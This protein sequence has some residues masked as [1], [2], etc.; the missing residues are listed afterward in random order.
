MHELARR[1]AIAH[2]L[3]QLDDRPQ[4]LVKEELFSECCGDAAFVT[5][6]ASKELTDQVWNW[7]PIVHA[8]K[9]ETVGQRLAS[10]VDDQMEFKAVEP[11]NRR[12]AAPGIDTKDAVLL[13]PGWMTDSE[14]RRI[15][16]A[17][18]GAGAE[19]GVQVDGKWYE[20]AW[21]ELN[22]AR[23]AEQVG[24]LLTQGGLHLLGVEAFK[25]P[26]A[27]VLEEDED[28]EHLGWMHP[29]CPA[30]ALA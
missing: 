17:V 10:I 16:E 7:L 22:K 25:G 13:D 30:V 23:V 15:T 12:P 6:K 20:E 28:G 8:A 1:S 26:I 19:L 21:H 5:E 29:N 11:S 4:T 2:V 24:K 3:A 27:R 18:A 9:G 14:G